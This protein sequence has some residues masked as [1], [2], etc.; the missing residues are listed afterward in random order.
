MAGFFGLFDYS[1]EGPGVKKNAPQK[2]RFIVFFELF[3]AKFWKLILVNLIFVL[4]LV[5]LL[6][7][8][9]GL[10]LLLAQMGAAN[11][12]TVILALAP[13]A[14]SG[15]VISGITRLTRDFVR[16]EP[17]FLWSDFLTTVKSNWKT[18]LVLSVISY[19]FAALM[20]VALPFYY[21]ATQV[22]GG[23]G[24]FAY[25]PFGMCMFA[26]V[27]FVFMQYYLY[28][29]LVTL[30]L[31]F[32]Q[33]LKNAVI[34]AIAALFRNLLVTIIIALLAVG[35]V[36]LGFVSLS[37]QFL[38]PIVIALVLMLFFSLCSFIINFMAFPVIK[39]L[40]IDPYYREHPEQT[41]EALRQKDGEGEEEQPERELPEYIY[42]NG[43]M[44]HR[45]VL[46][47]Q[48][49]FDDAPIRRGNED[50]DEEE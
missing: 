25:V 46:E 32:K 38:M 23:A 20:S 2:N 1:K 12:L 8:S 4:G 24:W 15:P 26:V 11:H 48:S 44:V 9:G 7:L 30:D 40:I 28:L 43:R 35:V 39:K 27:I 6:V 37:V 42:E 34:L 49:L 50:E 17:V 31:R 3:F 33:L 19:L 18:A 22:K 21:A 14:L 36:A 5:P 45:S 41:A 10:I 16:S 13:L 29:M 47:N